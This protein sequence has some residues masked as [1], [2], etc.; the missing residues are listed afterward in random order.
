MKT[1]LLRV[2]GIIFGSLAGLVLAAF[3]IY[4]ILY[5]PRKAEPFE[6]STLN[7]TK[8][9][10]IATQGSDFKDTL[11]K[12][13][14]D[15]LKQ[16]SVYIGGIDVGGLAEVNDAEWDRILIINSYIIWLNK[17]VDQF[18]TRTPALDKILV[19]VTSGGADW[20]PQPE[21]TVD[22][23]T[24]ASKKVYIHNLVHMI[25]DWID[26]EDDQRWEPDDY[27]LA[28][29]Y[30]S[31]VDIEAACEAIALEQ[32]RYQ[33]LYPNLVDVINR[34]GYR[35]LRLK[36]VPSALEVLRLN[37]SLF[38]DFWNVY[39]S[40]GEALLANGDRE[41]AIRNYREAVR[42]NPDSKSANDMLKKL[43][44]E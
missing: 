29:E 16:S 26:K 44:K 36:D 41:S 6:I 19:F 25:T 28:L 7:P 30:Y 27:L 9:I 10:L 5:Y 37:V 38:P 11:T 14:C 32:E 42:L 39:D 21:F 20:L 1:K 23:I 8:K 17:D 40:Y 12:V 22:A 13:L 34:V 4:V 18:I 33:A 43:C 24:S 3:A 15:S 31:Q 35:Y 2:I